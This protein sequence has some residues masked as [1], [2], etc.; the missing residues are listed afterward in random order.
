MW[1]ERAERE[2]GGEK[3]KGNGKDL[4][5]GFVFPMFSEPSQCRWNICHHIPVSKNCQS[6][7]IYLW[8]HTNQCLFGNMCHTSTFWFFGHSSW[9]LF[10]PRV[11]FLIIFPVCITMQQGIERSPCIQQSDKT[12]TATKQSTKTQREIKVGQDKRYK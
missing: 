4:D 9:H 1:T 7:C 8:L 5:F 6:S 12:Q 10:F 11:W 2:K 3:R